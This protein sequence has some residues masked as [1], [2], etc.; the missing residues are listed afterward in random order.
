MGLTPVTLGGVGGG[1]VTVK[2]VELVSVPS[3]VVTAMR[4]LVAPAGT[5]DVSWVA[6]FVRDGGVVPLNVTAVAPPR[7]VPLIVSRRSDRSACG[8]DSRSDN[9]RNCT[10]ERDDHQ[11]GN[12]GHDRRYDSP[13]GH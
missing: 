11:Q 7:S 4:P 1:V 12:S 10:R 5:V 9:R 2:V 3:A 8:V 6:E 13:P